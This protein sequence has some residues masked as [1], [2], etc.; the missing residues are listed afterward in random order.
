MKAGVCELGGAAVGR[1][2]LT[3]E[4]ASP[5]IQGSHNACAVAEEYGRGEGPSGGPGVEGS[6]RDP[7]AGRGDGAEDEV[8]E[9]GDGEIW[10]GGGVGEEG[11]GGGDG[12]GADDGVDGEEKGV[13][14]T[15]VKELRG[16]VR[17][18]R[19][20]WGEYI[21]RGKQRIEQ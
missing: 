13:E 9:G 1:G 5:H 21:Q 16:K 18:G 6:R 11:E 15:G 12:G 10:V 2:R 8:G 20:G 7:T 17:W 3:N 4:S 19:L 14:N